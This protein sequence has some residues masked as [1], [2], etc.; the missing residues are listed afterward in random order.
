MRNTDEEGA[1]RLAERLRWE[2]EDCEYR[3]EGITLQMTASLGCTTLRSSD[4]AA[5]LFQRADRAL[6]RAKESGRNRV[7]CN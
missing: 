2:I 1:R 3:W 6:Y 4:T 7:E 5:S